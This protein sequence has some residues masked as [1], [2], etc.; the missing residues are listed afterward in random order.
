MRV[1]S[2]RAGPGKPEGS[3]RALRERVLEIS[4]AAADTLAQARREAR[5]TARVTKIGAINETGIL[6]VSS[7]DLAEVTPL[8]TSSAV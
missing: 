4:A 3:A 6:L 7:R 2:V 8:A 5:M 1:L